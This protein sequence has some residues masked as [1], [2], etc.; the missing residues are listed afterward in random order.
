[1]TEFSYRIK[2]LRLN[3][4]L[5]LA[6]ASK[7]LQISASTL[8][9]FEK[10]DKLPDPITVVRMTALYNVDI[11]T[12]LKGLKECSVVTFNQ[13]DNLRTSAIPAFKSLMDLTAEVNVMVKCP[14]EYA[15]TDRCVAWIIPKNDFC[16]EGCIIIELVTAYTDG[17]K[18]LYMAK[19]KHMIGIY[20]IKNSIPYIIP[21]NDTSKRVNPR[22][23][24]VKLRGIIKEIIL[25]VQ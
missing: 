19:N 23:R 14:E 11:T 20:K 5:T 12:I 10:G 15:Y 2:N 18:V 8:S 1:M 6:D 21:L 4:N 22:A 25:K 9:K 3:A 7:E 13:A 16:R 24:G 17:D